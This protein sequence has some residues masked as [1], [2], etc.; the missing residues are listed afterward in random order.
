MNTIRK[1]FT[2]ALLLFIPSLFI[3][4]SC[5]KE[6][7]GPEPLNTPTSNFDYF[8]KAFDE[9]YGLFEVKNIDWT[10]LQLKYRSRVNDQM[11]DEQLYQ[12]ITEMMIQLNDNH[13][14]LYPTNGSLPVFPGG[15]LR[16]KDGNLRITKV[17]DDYDL[18]VV[19]KYL[20]ESHQ[21]SPNVTYG[22]L[23]GNVGYIGI[24][25]QGDSRKS[26]EKNFI[27]MINDLKDAKGI[28]VDVRGDYGGMDAI[29]QL[30]AGF[31]ASEK[32]L[33]MTTKKRNGPKHTDFT[34]TTEW[35]VEPQATTFI[36]PIIVLTSPFTQ[37]AGE[38]FTLAMREFNHVKIWGDT[39]AGSFSDNPNTEMPNGWIFSISVG[40]YRAAD[41]QSFEGIGI[42]PHRWVKTTRDNLLKDKDIALEE[43]IQE[44]TK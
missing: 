19:K 2:L 20:T 37:S 17:Q 25:G 8:W 42:A 44:L 18:D 12:V 35:Y 14:N 26:V 16:Y 29:A 33:Y 1:K 15:L 34:P 9:R 11:T 40:D 39:T 10:A 23:A 3:M 30:M 38:T 43:A 24:T 41:G 5:E 7:I 6:F 21:L 31:F 13:L 22:R 4:A 32:K 36:K 27:K 28:I